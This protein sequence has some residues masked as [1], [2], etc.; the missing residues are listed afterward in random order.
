M[1]SP[2]YDQPQTF[3]TFKKWLIEANLEIIKCEPGDNGFVAVGR[4]K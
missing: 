2:E 1:L 3:E 4:K